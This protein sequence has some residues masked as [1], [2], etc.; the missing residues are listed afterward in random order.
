M[1]KYTILPSRTLPPSGPV[2]PPARAAALPA[3]MSNERRAWSSSRRPATH[4][5]HRLSLSQLVRTRLDGLA[6]NG[7][8]AGC[9]FGHNA[10]KAGRKPADS[11]PPTAAIAGL[12]TS[13]GIQGKDPGA[14]GM[15]GI[16]RCFDSL[17]W[18][19]LRD[20]TWHP[21][22]SHDAVQACRCYPKCHERVAASVALPLGSLSVPLRNGV[23][24]VISHR[25]AL[26]GGVLLPRSTPLDFGWIR[27]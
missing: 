20:K 10:S 11:E 2:V 25:H 7:H 23:C 18:A 6:S 5:P 17:S 26:A 14:V 9:P 1:S 24:I 16:Y 15:L 21:S 3:A 8:D 22:P 19:T 27:G 13:N 4:P 12:R